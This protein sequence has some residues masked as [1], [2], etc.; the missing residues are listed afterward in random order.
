MSRFIIYPAIAPLVFGLAFVLYHWEKATLEL[1]AWN[2][3]SS[4]V[5][6]VVPSLIVA[7]VNSRGLRCK[8]DT[9]LLSCIL[10]ML[11]ATVLPFAVV[12]PGARFEP[13]FLLV[14]AVAAILATGVCYWISNSRSTKRAGAGSAIVATQ[15]EPVGWIERSKTRQKNRARG[16][17]MGFAPLNPSYTLRTFPFSPN[18][19]SRP[20]RSHFPR[21][22][23][24][25]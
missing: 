1:A 23:A 17:T 8:S 6:F 5:L 2:F 16:R 15:T 4:Y 9:H 25:A 21:S 11:L 13:H 22:A 3:G 7:A 19:H 20:A 14:M 10:T 18:A 12:I 24:A